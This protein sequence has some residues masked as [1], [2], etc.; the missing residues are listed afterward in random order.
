MILKAVK[1]GNTTYL[2]PSLEDRNARGI[3]AGK[4]YD[5]VWKGEYIKKDVV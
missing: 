2:K 1:I 5:V 4:Y 3:A